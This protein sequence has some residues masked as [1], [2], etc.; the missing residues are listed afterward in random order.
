MKQPSLKFG[1][2][3]LLGVL[4]PF[5]W[6]WAVSQLT[7]TVYAASGSPERATTTLVWTSIYAPSFVLG[8]IA[9]AIVVILSAPATW[10]GWLTFLGSLVLATLVLGV[11]SGAPLE[12]L[13]AVYRTSGNWFFFGGLVLATAF[14]YVRKR[15]I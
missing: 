8:V 10:A 14:A 3:A 12:Y 2:I 7:Y 9:G 1:A 13:E 11:I 4:A 6:T 15:T 5:W